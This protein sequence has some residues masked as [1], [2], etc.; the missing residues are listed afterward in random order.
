MFNPILYST[1]AFILRFSINSV[2]FMFIYLFILR[3]FIL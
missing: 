2:Y 1:D 3:T